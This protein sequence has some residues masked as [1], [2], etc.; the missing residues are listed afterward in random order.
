MKSKY[1]VLFI[2]LFGNILLVGRLLIDPFLIYCEPCILGYQCPPCQTEFAKQIWIYFLIWNLLVG[3]VFL[4]MKK[5]NVHT[6]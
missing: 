5:K 6:E 1:R 3:I 2:W 4:T